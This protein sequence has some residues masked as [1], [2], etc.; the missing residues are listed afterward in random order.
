MRC[1]S[2]GLTTNVTLNTHT[3][4]NWKMTPLPLTDTRRLQDVLQR[5]QQMHLASQDLMGTPQGGMTFYRGFFDV[6]EQAPHPLDT[7]L[8]LD[9]WSKVSTKVGT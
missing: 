1:L 9:G 5:L 3:L 7:F 6:P 4:T 2:Q 8:R